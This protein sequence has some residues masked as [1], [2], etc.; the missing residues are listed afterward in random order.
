MINWILSDFGVIK[1]YIPFLSQTLTAMPA[2]ILTNIWKGT[3]FVGIMLLAGLQAIP[4]QLYEQQ[5]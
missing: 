3:P 4:V 2:V 5:M 1:E